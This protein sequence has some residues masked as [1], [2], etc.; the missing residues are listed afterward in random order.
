MHTLLSQVLIKNIVH[1]QH[2]VVSMYRSTHIF[3]QTSTIFF[4]LQINISHQNFTLENSYLVEI[5]WMD[6]GQVRYWAWVQLCILV[7]I[8]FGV[9]STYIW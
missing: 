1:L 7:I 4:P 6:I 2:S 3:K 9:Y 8:F 5:L